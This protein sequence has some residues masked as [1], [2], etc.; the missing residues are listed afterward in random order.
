MSHSKDLTSKLTT[1]QNEIDAIRNIISTTDKELGLSEKDDAGKFHPLSSVNIVEKKLEFQQSIQHIKMILKQYRN[2]LQSTSASDPLLKRLNSLLR[3]T[4]NES[5]KL[6][7]MI[8]SLQQCHEIAGRYFDRHRHESLTHSFVFPERRKELIEKLTLLAK[9]L[10]GFNSY[11]ET[12]HDTD[13]ILSAA[14][15]STVTLTCPSFLIDIVIEGDGVRNV[16]V[17]LTLTSSGH[18]TA[19]TKLEAFHSHDFHYQDAL[20]TALQN[21]KFSDF[22]RIVRAMYRRYERFDRLRDLFILAYCCQQRISRNVCPLQSHHVDVA[23]M[24]FAI[25]RDLE[26]ITSHER[27]TFGVSAAWLKYHGLLKKDE[28]GRHLF[29]HV[30]PLQLLN[31]VDDLRAPI[32]DSP[33]SCEHTAVYSALLDI[34]LGHTKHST[35][36]LLPTDSQIVA[37]NPH[38]DPGVGHCVVFKARQSAEIQSLITTMSVES[39]TKTDAS[40]TALPPSPSSTTTT[41]STVALNSA[42]PTAHSAPA[43]SPSAASS[44]ISP[45]SPRDTPFL[46]QLI[47]LPFVNFQYVLCLS[48]PIPIFVDSL[49][50]LIAFIFGSFDDSQIHNH[51]LDYL[52]VELIADESEGGIPLL[53]FL[54]QHDDSTVATTSSFLSKELQIDMVIDGRKYRYVYCGSTPNALLLQRI[55]FFHISNLFPILQR[56]RQQLVYNELLSSCFHSPYRCSSLTLL[57]HPPASAYQSSPFLSTNSATTLKRSKI[58]RE[59]NL[60]TCNN[61]NNYPRHNSTFAITTEKS[62]NV[63]VDSSGT[64]QFPGNV[65]EVL[66]STTN[67]IDLHF[68]NPHTGTPINLQVLVLAGGLISASFQG[69]TS[70]IVSS[71]RFQLLSPIGSSSSR[72]SEYLPCSNHYIS[73]LLNTCHDI[74]LALSQLFKIR[75]TNEMRTPSS[76]DKINF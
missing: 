9:R 72:N 14:S 13:L 51:P 11:I 42:F 18:N 64:V 58:L 60:V 71:N 44:T 2:W 36:L 37:L 67:R 15:T 1:V 76:K 47:P 63:S 32:D 5:Q 54:L 49:R 62:N 25:E 20:L 68:M 39:V 55:P 69:C 34:E 73:E 65:I 29:Y 43:P 17:T 26:L 35:H 24:F 16:N 53:K 59:G 66:S 38:I 23:K 19:S 70:D 21:N 22:E 40:A 33:L 3:D 75:S 46:S 31:F 8:T 48:P 27:M 52:N 7:M 10:P 28:R 30:A 45:P 12:E 6:H 56:L 4:A 57:A 50:E 74:P 61:S 41:T